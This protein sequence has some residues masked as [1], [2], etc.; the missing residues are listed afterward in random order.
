MSLCQEMSH[1]AGA[2]KPF[3]V[4]WNGVSGWVGLPGDCSFLLHLDLCLSHSQPLL[5]SSPGWG[6]GSVWKGLLRLGS[7]LCAY[8]CVQPE[9]G[10]GTKGAEAFSKSDFPLCAL[11]EAAEMK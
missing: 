2:E 10:V 8:F 3:S 11:L 9:P 1:L 4:Q 5:L 7:S 6:R